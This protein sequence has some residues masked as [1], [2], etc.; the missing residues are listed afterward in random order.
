MIEGVRHYVLKHGFYLMKS[1]KDIAYSTTKRHVSLVY[2][3]LGRKANLES[4]LYSQGLHFFWS[5][6]TLSCL[7]KKVEFMPT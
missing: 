1:V 5:F 7:C 6:D 2:I 4:G 3:I